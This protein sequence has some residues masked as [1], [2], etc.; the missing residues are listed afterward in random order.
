MNPHCLLE[1]I[2]WRRLKLLKHKYAKEW[3]QNMCALALYSTYLYL[4]HSNLKRIFYFKTSIECLHVSWKTTCVFGAIQGYKGAHCPLSGRNTFTRYI[5]QKTFTIEK[6]AH[7]TPFLWQGS[8]ALP[9]SATTTEMW[10]CVSTL[11]AL[12]WQ[13]FL[14]LRTFKKMFLYEKSWNISAL[15]N[16]VKQQQLLLCVC[17]NNWL[18]VRKLIQQK[19]YGDNNGPSFQ[20]HKNLSKWHWLNDNFNSILFTI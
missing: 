15:I 20:G 12:G 1:L 18:F 17:C 14:S 6:E 3:I 2:T 8:T 19:F 7:V 4:L 5:P 10:Q 13:G 16:C 11:R 9:N